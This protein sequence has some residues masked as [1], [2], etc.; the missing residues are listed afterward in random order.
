MAK[1]FRAC[2][3]FYRASILLRPKC[4]PSSLARASDSL[5]SKDVLLLLLLQSLDRQME[6]EGRLAYPRH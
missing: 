6:L 2:L 4:G 3:T 5:L 1:K